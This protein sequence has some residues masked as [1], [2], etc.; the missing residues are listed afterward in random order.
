M[1]KAFHIVFACVCTAFLL[2][3][4][5]SA[6]TASSY[7]VDRVYLDSW[8]YSLDGQQFSAMDQSLLAD[9][10]PLLSEKDGGYI[11]LRTTVDFS[12]NETLKGQ[13]LSVYLGHI[14]MANIT[15]FNG[16]Q[17]G[18]TGRMPPRE[19]SSWNTARLYHIP[20]TAVNPDGTNTITVKIWTHGEGSLVSVPFIAATPVAAAAAATERFWNSQIHL[21]CAFVML[22]MAAY[23]YLLWLKRRQEK[24]N[25]L[26]ATINII[27]ALY[28]CVF[29]LEEIP[30][31]PTAS[32]DF[33]W[34]QKIF[35]SSMPFLLPYLVTS[36]IFEYLKEKEH[37]IIRAV[38]LAFVVIPVAII[39]FA[40]S[41][42]VL[43]AIRN[44][45]Q[46]FL[47]PPVLYI[48]YALIRAQTEKKEDAGALFMGFIPLVV[49]VCM[50]LF[51][52]NVLN[53]VF[54]YISTLGWM[55]V[56]L[57]LLFILAGRFANARTVAEELNAN[58][59]TKVAERTSEL[60]KANDELATYRE[61]AERD[62]QLAVQVQQSFLPKKPPVTEGY[63]IAFMFKPQSG[64]S[65]DLY[66]FYSDGEHL[67]GAALFDVSGHGI[68][69]GLV[70]MLAKNII[71]REFAAG[72]K[73]SLVQVMKSI[74]ESL[75]EDKGDIENYLTGV[76]LRFTGEH[77]EYVNAGHPPMM[78]RTAASQRV[79]EAVI[80]KEGAG[81]GSLVGLRGL[82]AEF[83]AIGFNMKKDDCLLFYTD[84]LSE[85]R[86]QE[87]EPYGVER[88]RKSF[89]TSGNGS[90][91]DK[92]DLLMRD[93]AGFCGETPLNDDLTVI[94]VQKK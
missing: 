12:A 75:V 46:M 71:S 67:T 59:E 9:L 40:P 56:I 22:V 17:I 23:H 83:T 3:S 41:Y 51:I 77:V 25:A 7:P 66:D 24:E 69:S 45:T 70:T 6:G 48:A 5:V 73:K 89:Q 33:L 61:H 30:G 63:D 26:F 90:A 37:H 86:N 34:F 60:Q 78:V 82:P 11:W 21:L 32:M 38:R 80:A 72:R 13:D 15:W 42:P 93:F 94:L 14:T 20:D 4:C 36:F 58:L 47:V 53:I 52:H 44:L 55:A 54:P 2:G 50:D 16:L 87:G 84:C 57:T 81:Q 1:K 85:S 79:Q 65:G 74:N 8:T 19:F 35:S 91:R 39:L 43:R 64:V 10:T 88:I 62:M 28:L 31:F 49:I 92:L 18:A 29:Y 76:L 68:A 27:S